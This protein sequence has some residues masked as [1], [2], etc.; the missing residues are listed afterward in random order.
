M[1]SAHAQ[2]EADLESPDTARKDVPRAPAVDMTDLSTGALIRLQQTAGNQFVQRF[3]AEGAGNGQRLQREPRTT[4]VDFEP[5]VITVPTHTLPK[6]AEGSGASEV[7]QLVE[8]QATNLRSTQVALLTGVDN[9]AEYQKF[10]SSKE[11]K[12]DYASVVLKF[13]IKQLI[14]IALKDIATEM[15]GW[16]M[17]YKITFGLAEELEKEHN[18]ALKAGSEV[19]ARDF[20]VQYRQLITDVFNKLIG[21]VPDVRE[22]LQND[23]AK[24][25]HPD[26]TPAKKGDSAPVPGLVVGNRAEF[27]NGLKKAFS[28]YKVPTADLC[29]KALTEAWVLKAE[30][31]LK[32]RGGGDIYADGRIHLSM[33]IAKDGEAYEI[34]EWPKEGRLASPRADHTID[35]LTRVFRSGVAKSTNDLEIL[36]VL[37]IDVEDEV[38]GFNDHYH[39]YV[40]FR[41]AGNI[42]EMSTIPSPVDSDT[43]PKAHAVGARAIDLVWPQAAR[44]GVTELSGVPEGEKI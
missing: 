34:T 1:A 11:A 28:S 8:D 18:R 26:P 23:F 21:Q 5:E 43:V 9:F 10:A 30:D 40:K 39:V 12:A 6:S 24:L 44:L 38:F 33:H 2:R 41:N 22:G 17:V 25:D 13:A 29:L 32:S 4:T 37:T 27:L 7:N 36:K 42:E 35:A 16:A 19:E 20:I 15:P 14:D 3:I 31:H